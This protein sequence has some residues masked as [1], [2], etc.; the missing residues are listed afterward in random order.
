MSSHRTRLGRG[1]VNLTVFL[2]V[3]FASQA[4]FRSAHI[5]ITAR[6][7]ASALGLAVYLAG[8]RGIEGQRPRELADVWGAVELAGGVALGIGLFSAV[9]GLLWGFGSYHPSGF[10]TSAGLAT[11]G[12]LALAT[13]ILEETLFRGF[14]FRLSSVVVGTWGALIFTSILFG[15]AHAA[16][17]SATLGSS[18]AIALEAG[19]LL[20][21][22]YAV[23]GRLWLPIGLHAGWNFAEGSLFGM[24]VSGFSQQPALIAGQV[25][26]PSVLTGGSFGPEASILAVLVCVAAAVVL[27]WRTIRLHRVEMP[28]WKC[29]ESVREIKGVDQPGSLDGSDG[30]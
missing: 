10:G 18:I 3:V 12:L 29:A 26:G 11:G 22:A 21:G 28:L 27:L 17:P 7:L 19:V 13:G 15:A 6:I 1:A 30:G 16:N 5:G 9:M 8:V 24:A 4:Y 2:A 25:S 20:G 14:L 23:T